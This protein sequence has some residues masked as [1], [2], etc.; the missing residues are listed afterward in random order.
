MIQRVPEHPTGRVEVQLDANGIPD[1]T[2]IE[3]TAYDHIDFEAI[4]TPP[5]ME[6]IYFGSLIQRTPASRDRLHRFLQH[7]AGSACRLYDV[8]FR[9]GCEKAEILIPSLEQ[10]DVLKLNEE[11]LAAAGRMIGSSRQG[12]EL[13]VELMD[14][15]N[16]Q[17]IAVTRGAQGALLYRAGNKFE[18]PAGPLQQE[19][20]TDTVGAG[21][22]FAAV[23][24][25]GLLKDRPPQQILKR[26]IRL[27]ENI[28]TLAGAV[29][30]NTALYRELQDSAT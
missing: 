12:D 28:C 20:I 10:T 25:E 2:I 29:P 21:D 3:N 4:D 30:E 6:L 9:K 8:N 16:L 24:A 7:R 26:A 1:Y 23:L 22:A 18:A 27:A 19:Q 5:D 15:F 17:Q 13:A 11:E 14:R